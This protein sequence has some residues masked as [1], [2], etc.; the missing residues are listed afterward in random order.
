VKVDAYLQSLLDRLGRE[1]PIGVL[2]RTP[3]HLDALL[4][5]LGADAFA[6][7]VRPGGWT[8][9]ETIAHLADVELGMGFRLRQAVGG[10]PRAQGFD[11][12]QWASR[13]G[14]LD[15]S[16]ALEV[17]RAVRAWNLALLATFDLDDWLSDYQHPERGVESVDMLVRSLAGHDLRHLDA[18]AALLG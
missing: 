2:G 16:L 11:Q 14:R 6:L 9:G 17:L 18:I 1:D 10:E 8:V 4:E 13:Y 7:E 3:E 15:A 5:R 12:D